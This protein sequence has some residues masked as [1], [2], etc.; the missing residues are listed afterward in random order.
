MNKQ[1]QLAG[2]NREKENKDRFASP[3]FLRVL[4][5]GSPCCFLSSGLCSFGLV[6]VFSAKNSIAC[7]RN[8]ISI[9]DEMWQ[10]RNVHILCFG[11]IMMSRDASGTSSCR[12]ATPSTSQA[13]AKATRY[14]GRLNWQRGNDA[15]RHK[16]VDVIPLQ[17][18]QWLDH[19]ARQLV[20]SFGHSFIH[21][22]ACPHGLPLSADSR[23]SASHALASV[24]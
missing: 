19:R 5:P 24:Q 1:L 9:N 23:V 8:C 6:G 11:G 18:T 17:H 13:Y 10:E 16:H 4:V 7:S 22:S 21:L 3:P 2:Q 15:L 14:N 12:A 20:R